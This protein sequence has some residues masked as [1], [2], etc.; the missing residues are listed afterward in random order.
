MPNHTTWCPNLPAWEML[1]P[2]LLSMVGRK[3]F[4]PASEQVSLIEFL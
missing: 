3:E 4:L 1:L 2:F